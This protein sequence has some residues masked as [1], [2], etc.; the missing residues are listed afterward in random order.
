MS[1]ASNK[2]WKREATAGLG[3]NLSNVDISSF[4]GNV[5]K[6]IGQ[7]ATKTLTVELRIK[8]SNFGNALSL[9]PNI[10]NFDIE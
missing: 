9:H 5:S 6:E 7:I 8:C 2:D 1:M 4:K 3:S 10:M